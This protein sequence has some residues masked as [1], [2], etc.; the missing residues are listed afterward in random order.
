M[1]LTDILLGGWV[2]LLWGMAD[3]AATLSTRHLTTLTTTILAHFSGLLTLLCILVIFLWRDPFYVY[4]ISTNSLFISLGT[5]VLT[6]I[7]YLALY[8][9]L[10]LGPI[11]ITSPLSST[12]AVFT[13]VL[14]MLFLQEHM[15]LYDGL[16]IGAIIIGVFLASLSVQDMCLHLR[17]NPK[18]LFTEKGIGWACISPIAFGLVDISIGVSSPHYGWFVPVFL[19]FVFSSL[20]LTLLFLVRHSLNRRSETLFMRLSMLLR[21]PV[22]VLFAIG[23]GILECSAIIIFAIATQT[24]KPGLIAA[25]A[26]NYA[27]IAILFG[28]YVLG[29]RLMLNQKLGIGVVLCGL[30]IIAVIHL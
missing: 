10:K 8:R 12:S 6:V 22:G 5:G 19:T 29:E 1:P 2:A 7:G 27:L 3:S 26:S 30:T 20:T 9:A 28:V 14:S 15:T 21:Q 24:C 17:S 4:A 25:I 13:L 11:A 16:C 23:A 18:W